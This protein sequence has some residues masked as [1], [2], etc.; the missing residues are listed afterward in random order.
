MLKRLVERAGLTPWPRIFHNLRAS[1]E[2][3][4]V[5]HY[6]LHVVARWL[7]HSAVIA[8][9]HYLQLRD[10]HF[11]KAAIH[12]A[13][14]AS[15]R[16]NQRGQN[17][18]QQA[19]AVPAYTGTV[20]NRNEENSA[21]TELSAENALVSNDADTCLITP[22]GFEPEMRVPKTLVL[23]VTPRGSVVFPTLQSR[24]VPGK[25]GSPGGV[26]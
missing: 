26:K 7:G 17:R 8:N 10:D 23:P 25:P 13:F 20:R 19:S 11:Q 18:G 21:E 1:C 14:G 3:E 2:T 6:P 24:H 15:E 4:L 9:K 5:E 22:S 16:D 12:G